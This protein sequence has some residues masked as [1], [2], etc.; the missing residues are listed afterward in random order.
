MKPQYDFGI[1]DLLPDP[2]QIV[3]REGHI[4]FMNEKMREMFGNLL[5]RV[6]YQTLKE[7]G[8]EYQNCPR[9]IPKTRGFRKRPATRNSR[10]RLNPHRFRMDG[11]FG[12]GQHKIAKT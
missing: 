8:A 2:I 3:D 10:T 1:L 6:C 4:V 12:G 11:V 5:G 7:S 9:N